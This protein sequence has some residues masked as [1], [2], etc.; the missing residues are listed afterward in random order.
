[1]NLFVKWTNQKLG[2]SDYNPIKLSSASHLLFET[3]HPFRDGNGRVGRILLS[4]MLLG[5][6]F[7]NIAIKGISKNERDKYY[8]ALE[9]G[10]DQIE[11]LLRIIEKGKKITMKDIDICIDNSDL[12][13]LNTIISDRLIDST[14]R[15]R[16]QKKIDKD[17]DAFLPL[18]EIA[19]LYGYSQDYLRNLINRDNLPA[20]K[21][22][23]LWFVK[24]KDIEKYI[25]L[26]K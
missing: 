10:D 14:N 24:V 7:V 12:S 17:Q 25:N 5:Q 3:I 8:H 19:I 11:K 16:T 13:F 22:G 4:F 18:R 20:Q 23:K 1:M 21:R 26:L 15:L 2:T 9:I 6:G